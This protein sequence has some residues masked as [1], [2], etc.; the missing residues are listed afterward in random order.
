MNVLWITIESILPA[1]SGGRIGI[2]RRLEYIAKHNDI[3]LFYTM[4]SKGDEQYVN[5]LKE[6][7]K[8]VYGFVREK[9]SVTTFKS[10]SKAPFTVASRKNLAM[11]EKI[12][13]CLKKNNIDVINVDSP[14]MG[15]N[16]LEL[17]F[18]VP[19]VLNQHNVEW[20]VYNNIASATSKTI[21]KLVYK[22]EAIRFKKFEKNL[23]NKLDI[24]LMTFVSTEDRD[25]FIKEYPDLR[26]E[27]VP[28]GAIYKGYKYDWEKKNNNTMVFVG[29]MSYS[30]NIEA[31][32]WFCKFVFPL[33]KKE[34]S[35]ARLVI[36][37]KD[38]T[39]DV[40]SL[41]L[42]DG[43]EV[44]GEVQSLDEYYVNADLDVIPLLHGG[45]V[46][47][48]LL[49]GLGY[50]VPIVTTPV[51]AQGTMFDNSSLLI[52]DTAEEMASQC[53][54]F[55]KE[56]TKYKEMYEN[57]FSIFKEKYTWDEIGKHYEELLCS[58]ATKGK[59]L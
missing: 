56:K 14:H 43:V 17:D 40:L 16:L 30:P 57:T 27:L 11:I 47:V 22:F 52:S 44:T 21:K 50:S 34:I 45:G 31:V 36:V 10:L 18:N 3:F 37:G 49:E 38:P 33:I 53:I 51:G 7:C 32:T 46:K 12:K 1:N 58:V 5:D 26:T 39:K 24:S 59:T 13:E 41:E 6:Y 48:K 9:K 20:K 2:F 55:L 4:D 28:V 29:K 42:I 8:E 19:I 15:L 23:Y 25:Y 54:S 35:D